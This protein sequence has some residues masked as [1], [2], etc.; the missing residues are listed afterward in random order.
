M[1]SDVFTCVKDG[2]PLVDYLDPESV[3][4][5]IKETHQAYYDRFATYFGN[6]I[7]QTFL[8]NQHYIAE[9]EESGPIS[10]MKSL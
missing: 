8:M 3:K 2:S 5:F 1:E 10:L 7:I 4:L 6:V 9:M